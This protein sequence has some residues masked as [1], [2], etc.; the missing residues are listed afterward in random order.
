MMLAYFAA[1]DIKEVKKSF[2][3]FTEVASES[4]MKRFVSDQ[5]FSAVL[6]VVDND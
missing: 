2:E 5:K 4:D 3:R 6:R 1:D